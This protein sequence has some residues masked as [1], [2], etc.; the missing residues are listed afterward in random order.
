MN[1]MK[2]ELIENLRLRTAEIAVGPSTVRGAGA[3]GVTWAARAAL[4]RVPL[5][6]FRV[7]TRSAFERVLESQTR[8]IQRRLPRGAQH[9]GVARKVLNIFLRSVV[10][11]RHLCSAY[12]LERTEQWLEVPLDR[13]VAEGIRH[14]YPNGGLPR[15]R[16]IKGLVPSVSA[17]YQMAGRS[18][19]ASR[20]V[21][22]VHLEYYWWRVPGHADNRRTT[23]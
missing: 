9:W 22:P 16:T 11:H 21:H 10:F 5:R 18:T 14:A 3:R 20:G 4:K 1:R 8:A 19:A 7:P 2:R 23:A 17:V 6:R 12:G 15:W 13:H